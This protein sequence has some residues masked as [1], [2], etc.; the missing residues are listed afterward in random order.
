MPSLS[1]TMDKGTIVN[2]RVKEG[3][4]IV[5]GDVLCEIETD[6]AKLEFENQED[7]YYIA[8]I[9]KP[10]GSKDV[11]LGETIAIVAENQDD[12]SK[13]ANISLESL[14]SSSSTGGANA[15]AST[16]AATTSSTQSA[17]TTS[18]TQQSDRFVPE[19]ISE[20]KM[21]SLSPTMTKGNIMKWNV[22]PGEKIEPGDVLCAVETD[23]ATVEFEFQEHGYL[24]QILKPEGTHDVNL[25]EVIALLAEDKD[26]VSRASQ[27]KAGSGA[28]TVKTT[29][30]A[31]ET[32]ATTTTT[33][34]P[35]QQQATTSAT[36]ATGGRV[37][38]SPLA[39][40][41]AAEQGVN[42]AQIGS[43]SGENN[44]IVKADVEEFVAS[45]RA[46]Q[47]TVATPV[48]AAATAAAPKTTAAAA[49]TAEYTDIP[50]SNIRK[51][52]A[53]R[54]LESKRNIPHYYLTVECEIDALMKARSQLNKAGE[55]RGF[56]LSVNDF[57]VKAASLAMKKVPEV[58]SSWRDTHIRQ[59]KNVDVSVAV[60]TDNGLITP[61]VFNAEQ[62]G[63][64]DI[65]NSVKNLAE[66]ARQ[67]KLQPHEFQGG[68]FTI[69]NLG[70]FGISEFAAIINPPQA[71]ILAVGAAERK[72]VPND[73]ATRPEDDKYKVVT[74]VKVTLSC[75]HRVVDGAVGAQWLQE[76]KTHIENPMFLML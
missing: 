66:R 5:P 24:A 30:K 18:A 63:L 23:K 75:D 44:R 31:A 43:G 34:A 14:V 68:T 1:P 61:I 62:K 12:I 64:S 55:K 76:F 2:W 36:T 48:A 22:Q 41:I 21:P 4:K 32:T 54:L 50:V 73:A 29:P 74:T 7:G 40:K 39:K 71:C 3:D 70:M 6:K 9:L 56:K 69:S 45:G 57:I 26:A 65:S 67:G 8:K 25:G 16:P 13:A 28:V 17:T 47:A 37:F 53:D 58:N 19:G 51:V 27:Y 11:L 49:E 15:S 20:I 35:Q 52:I 60:Q 72:V 33:T 59:F 46:K 10:A 42:L 38:A